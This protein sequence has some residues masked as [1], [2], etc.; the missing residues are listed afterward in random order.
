MQKT[1]LCKRCETMNAKLRYNLIL[2]C[3]GSKFQAIAVVKISYLSLLE[4]FWK[5]FSSLRHTPLTPYQLCTTSG[6]GIYFPDMFLSMYL[7]NP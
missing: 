7:I 4:G 2:Y 1:W 6:A 3:L 5:M